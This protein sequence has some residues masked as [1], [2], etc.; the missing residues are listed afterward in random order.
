[1]K[2]VSAIVLAL[3]VLLSASAVALAAPINAK[4]ALPITIYCPSGTYAAVVNGNGAF[5][6]AHAVN[7]NTVL[8]PIAFG[9]FVATIDDVVVEDDP[10]TVKGGAAPANGRVETCYY[11]VQFD[12]PDGLFEGTGTVTGFAA[13]P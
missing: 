8:I 13:N 7:S 3:I 1:M 10:P 6:A 2:A 9:E 5:T 12:T 11:T 4:R